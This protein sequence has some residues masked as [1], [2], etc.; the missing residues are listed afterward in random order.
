[1][2]IYKEV[3]FPLIAGPNVLRIIKLKTTAVS[4][5]FMKTLLANNSLV[6]SDGGVFRIVRY[7][8]ML[9]LRIKNI[10]NTYATKNVMKTT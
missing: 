9:A 2:T 10:A 5:E 6:T 8:S 1:M 7:D 3:V 4:N